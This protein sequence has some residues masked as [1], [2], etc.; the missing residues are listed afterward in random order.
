M[1][2]AQGKAPEDGLRVNLS[3]RQQIYMCVTERKSKPW[4][5]LCWRNTWAGSCS[6]TTPPQRSTGGVVAGRH[7]PRQCTRAAHAHLVGSAVVKHRLSYTASTCHDI[8]GK[9]V[10][11]IL[12]HTPMCPVRPSSDISKLVEEGSTIL[13]RPCCR[14]QPSISNDCRCI[15]VTRIT[16][17]TVLLKLVRHLHG[18]GTTPNKMKKSTRELGPYGLNNAIIAIQRNA[19]VVRSWNWTSIPENLPDSQG[20]RPAMICHCSPSMLHA[21][22][23]KMEESAGEACIPGRQGQQVQHAL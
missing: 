19:S 4:P 21:E 20:R 13:G 12:L 10:L 11:F 22:D 6:H 7:Q 23:C 17:K 5:E 3:V 15:H 16:G 2:R 1:A 14:T 8:Y 9:M 18:G